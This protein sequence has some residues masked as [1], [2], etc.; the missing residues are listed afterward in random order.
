MNKTI[1]TLGC[2]TFGCVLVLL[3]IFWIQPAISSSANSNASLLDPSCSQDSTWRAVRAKMHLRAGSLLDPKMHLRAGSLPSSSNTESSLTGVYVAK[4]TVVIESQ[5][6]SD[7]PSTYALEVKLTIIDTDGT[8]SGELSFRGQNWLISLSF[9]VSGTHKLKE[10]KLK[11]KVT[12]CLESPTVSVNAVVIPNG[13]LLVA[14]GMQLL[15]C[16]FER[17]RMILPEEIRFNR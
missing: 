16:N 13:S 11:L 12:M 6:G 2:I 17:L 1:R 5:D 14:K 7:V 15:T 4:A 8:V 9:P 10:A 3:Q